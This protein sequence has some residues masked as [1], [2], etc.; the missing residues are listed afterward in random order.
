MWPPE[1][2][3]ALLKKLSE[4]TKRDVAGKCDASYYSALLE[5]YHA[6]P[7]TVQRLADKCYELLKESASH[8]SLSFKR[9]GR[10]VARSQVQVRQARQ[11]RHGTVGAFA[12]TGQGPDD[13]RIVK[14]MVHRSVSITRRPKFW[15]PA[16]PLIHPS[17]RRASRQGKPPPGPPWPACC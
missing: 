2:L 9:V 15:P 1:N 5:A 8:P 3:I 11:M 16:I 17:C 10:V 13:N 7:E 14:S 4:I 12:G 6:L